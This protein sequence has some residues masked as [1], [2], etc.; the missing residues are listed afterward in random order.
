MTEVYDLL[1][2]KASLTY[3][4]QQLSYK[5]N[6]TY[7]NDQLDLK[8]D[9]SNTYTMSQVDN[10]LTPKA[11]K[12]DVDIELAKKANVSDMAIALSHNHTLLTATSDLTIY[13]LYAKSIEPPAGTTIIQLRTNTISFGTTAY[14][15]ITSTGYTC[16]RTG[17][18]DPRS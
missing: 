12:A 7:V 3:V 16:L 10:L 18:Y 5:A 1:D 11:I 17:V 6:L 14:A 2:K 4:N 13:R 9:K 15:T 8:A